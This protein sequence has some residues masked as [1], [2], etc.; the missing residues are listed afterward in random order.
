MYNKSKDVDTTTK[1]IR[2][3]NPLIDKIDYL[4]KVNDRDF[5]K[6]VLHMLKEYIRIKES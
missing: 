4:A 2:I 5:T 6:Q 1:S 3:P